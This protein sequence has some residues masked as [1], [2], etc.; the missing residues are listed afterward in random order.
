MGYAKRCSVAL[1]VADLGRLGKQFDVIMCSEVRYSDSGEQEKTI[2][3]G[4]NSIV[5]ENERQIGNNL[6]DRGSIPRRLLKTK[7]Q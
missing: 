2:R 6:L 7:S 3:E 4:S 5:I 1:C